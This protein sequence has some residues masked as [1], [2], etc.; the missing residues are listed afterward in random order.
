MNEGTLSCQLK[1]PYLF[2]EPAVM[3]KNL[4]VWRLKQVSVPLSTAVYALPI[5][6]SKG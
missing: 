4:K 5:I 1:Y 6:P 3:S 2:S